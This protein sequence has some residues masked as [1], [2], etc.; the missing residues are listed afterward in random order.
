M[1]QRKEKK[2]VTIIMYGLIH[3]TFTS[4]G[5]SRKGVVPYLRTAQSVK[6]RAKAGRL[7]FDSRHRQKIY[8]F[9]ITSRQAQ[10]PTQPPIQ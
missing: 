8:L 4:P 10:G 1:K 6:R 5:S 9:S 2:S 3:I 7:G